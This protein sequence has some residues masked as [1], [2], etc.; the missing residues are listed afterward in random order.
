MRV[1]RSGHVTDGEG[2][3]RPPQS[4]DPLGQ[5]LGNGRAGRLSVELVVAPPSAIQPGPYVKQR[6]LGEKAGI[7]RDSFG[8]IVF[9]GLSLS[10]SG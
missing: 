5:L 7:S 6:Y 9:I 1:E 8:L 10:K 3:L 4:A 2:P